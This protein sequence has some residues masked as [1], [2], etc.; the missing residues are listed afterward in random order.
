MLQTGMFT[1]IKSVRGMSTMTAA[2]V[3]EKITRILYSG[4]AHHS[5]VP[6]LEGFARRVRILLIWMRFWAQ[7]IAAVAFKDVKP[8]EPFEKSDE[9]VNQTFA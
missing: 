1:G 3:A 5:L 4:R 6:A 7:D 9:G 8:H 2:Y